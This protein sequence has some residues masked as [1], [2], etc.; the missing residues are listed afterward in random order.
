[1]FATAGVPS[2]S[3]A[4][5]PVPASSSK[6]TSPPSAGPRRQCGASSSSYNAGGTV[7]CGNEMSGRCARTTA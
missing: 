5:S 4:A 7:V 6:L 2:G 1:M 3:V